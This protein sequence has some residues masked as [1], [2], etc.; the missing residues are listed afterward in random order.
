MTIL[1]LDQLAEGSPQKGKATVEC[2]SALQKYNKDIK[3]KGLYGLYIY[4]LN[5][6]G[7]CWI[8]QCNILS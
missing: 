5:N 3:G 7:Q 1:W 2:G 4:F 6:K 8:V